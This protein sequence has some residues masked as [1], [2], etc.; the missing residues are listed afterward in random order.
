MQTTAATGS[1]QSLSCD[2]RQMSGNTEISIF[3]LLILKYCE[4]IF[5][6]KK[7][8]KKNA[9]LPVLLF[10]EIILRPELYSPRRFQIQGG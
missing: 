8:K 2:V 1:I 9:I 5:F 7:K 4:E 6:E 10:R 3:F